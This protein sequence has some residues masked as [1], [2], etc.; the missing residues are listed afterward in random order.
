MNQPLTVQRL[1]EENTKRLSLEWLAGHKG[2]QRQ[3]TKRSTVSGSPALV[4]YFNLIHANQ[5]Q[6]L[7][8]TELSYL[9]GLQDQIL[10]DACRQLFESKSVV[11][12]ITDRQYPPAKFTELA[13]HYGIALIRSSLSSYEILT[14]L[15]YYFAQKLADRMTLHGVFLEVLSIGVVLTGDSGT[16]KS[17]LA[18]EL[19]SRGHRLIAD[20]APEFA[21]IAPDTINGSCPSL[22]QDFLEVRGLGVLN[23]RA[24]YG[25]SAIKNNKHLRL[26]IHLTPILNDDALRQ[27][28]LQI[29]QKMRNILGVDIP[30]FSLPVAPG[31]N[32]SV[33]V[34]AAV[35]N[36]LLRLNGY[37]AGEDLITRQ[38]RLM[39]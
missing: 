30:V 23:I 11:I 34:E 29:E 17:E 13:E 9:K 33:L 24:M 25:D 37:N 26:I 1:Y 5:T 4:G 19:I 38:R 28:R 31:R 14:N 12:I 3:F 6:V 36:H 16:G 10:R 18:L 2:A 7:G 39:R 22:L 20:D 27:D 35:R 32:L 15:R 21:R 8:K